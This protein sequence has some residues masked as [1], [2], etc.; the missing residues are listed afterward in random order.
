M[1]KILVVLLLMGFCAYPLFAQEEEFM[2]NT[3][4]QE[5]KEKLV[6]QLQKTIF[7]KNQGNKFMMND[8]LMIYTTVID[9]VSKKVLAGGLKLPF[10]EIYRRV[11]NGVFQG[12]AEIRRERHIILRERKNLQEQI[13]ALEKIEPLELRVPIISDIL[14]KY[15]A[16]NDKLINTDEILSCLK[17][18]VSGENIY[19]DVVQ[20]EKLI[21]SYRNGRQQL[22]KAEQENNRNISNE[23]NDIKTVE[24]DLETIN[25]ELRKLGR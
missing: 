23:E 17:N 16:R 19:M 13:R 10:E 2:Q 15:K 8:S 6:S 4:K 3:R 1:K 5:Q 9:L 21:E 22:L 11:E 24:K 12:I 25:K 7:L 18:H 20:L 14:K